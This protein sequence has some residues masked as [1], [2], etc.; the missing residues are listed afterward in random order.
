MRYRGGE[1]LQLIN[2]CNVELTFSSQVDKGCYYYCP[3]TKRHVIVI[4]TKISRAE[5]EQ[6]GWHEFGHLLQNYFSPIPM[7]AG[8]CQPGERTPTEHFADLFAFVCITGVPMCGR[9]DFLET[10]MSMRDKQ[11]DHR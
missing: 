2:A 8:Y 11:H 7:R 10:L 5:R 6:V 4:S 1:F 9:M 3:D